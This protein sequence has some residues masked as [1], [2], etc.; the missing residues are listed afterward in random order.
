[1]SARTVIFKFDLGDKIMLSE[2]QRPGVV[3]GLM[4]GGNGTQYRVVYWNDSKREIE[5]CYE[6]E[7]ELR[8]GQ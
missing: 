1:M 3:D 7:I 4:F 5:L 2:I 8:R 6:W